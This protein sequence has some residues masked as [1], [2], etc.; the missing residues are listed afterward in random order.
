ME[1]CK[2]GW[3]VQAAAESTLKLKTAE[4]TA[5]AEAAS[6]QRE[7]VEQQ[8]KLLHDQ[9]ERLSQSLPSGAGGEL[10]FAPLMPVEH[11]LPSALAPLLHVYIC[12]DGDRQTEVQHRC[13]KTGN[14]KL[15]LRI[16]QTLD[17]QWHKI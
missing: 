4:L 1:R 7:Q 11:R 17:H 8:N 5:A 10:L 13:F 6:R 3:T 15:A 16:L 14:K 2:A 12:L 9:L